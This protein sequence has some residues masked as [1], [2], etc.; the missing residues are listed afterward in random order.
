MSYSNQPDECEYDPVFGRCWRADAHDCSVEPKPTPPEVPAPDDV[1]LAVD[2]RTG[3]VLKTFAGRLCKER[4]EAW[5]ADSLA[6][7]VRYVRAREG[8]R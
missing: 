2:P 6:V 8:G 4:C 3:W 1:W 5:A 7:A